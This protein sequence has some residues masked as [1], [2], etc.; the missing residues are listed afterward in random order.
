MNST[1]TSVTNARRDGKGSCFGITGNKL[2]VSS[3]ARL[4]RGLTDTPSPVGPPPSP[5]PRTACLLRSRSVLCS[6]KL[7]PK[8]PS[9][10]HFGGRP[11][12]PRPPAWP[13]PSLGGHDGALSSKISKGPHC[14]PKRMIIWTLGFCL[15]IGLFHI[16]E[17]C[18]AHQVA[19]LEQK[20]VCFQST[21]C[22]YGGKF[23]FSK[24]NIAFFSPVFG[25]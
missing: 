23:E 2:A 19:Y 21:I 18:R 25:L 15:G 12:R 8:R 10:S 3:P 13:W 6:D 24:R 17:S 11:A 1:L 9:V 4:A 20:K 14:A 5:L 16:N 7:V 22:G